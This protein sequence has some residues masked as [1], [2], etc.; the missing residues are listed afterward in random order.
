VH[1]DTPAVA[2][3]VVDNRDGADLAEQL[4]AITGSGGDNPTRD[5]E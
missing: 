5:P 3:F 1:A 4:D 2:H